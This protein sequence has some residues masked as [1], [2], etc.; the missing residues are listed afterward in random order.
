MAEN[1]EQSNVHEFEIFDIVQDVKYEFLR[2]SY[3]MAF[4]IQNPFWICGSHQ[5]LFFMKW[6]TRERSSESY[7]NILLIEIF[8]LANFEVPIT[9]TIWCF[10]YLLYALECMSTLEG[11]CAPTNR[12]ILVEVFSMV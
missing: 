1:Y 12:P 8:W 3:A 9:K 11:Y 10:K 7:R 5:S 6:L 4:I 2:P